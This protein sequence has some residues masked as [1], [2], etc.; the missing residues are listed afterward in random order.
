MCYLCDGGTYDELLF[1]QYGK[2]LKY[3]FTT[4]MIESPPLWAYTI[5][6]VESFGI[7]NSLWPGCLP[8]ARTR[9]ST[10]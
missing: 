9:S 1:D 5:G 4:V 6:L 7:R 10:R 8:A 2:I 3:G